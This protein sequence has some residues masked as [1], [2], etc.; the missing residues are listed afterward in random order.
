MNKIM[1]SVV[2]FPD[3]GGGVGVLGD[4]EREVKPVGDVEGGGE[5]REG[6]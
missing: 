2:L 5:T 1:S 4:E 6:Y 3:L